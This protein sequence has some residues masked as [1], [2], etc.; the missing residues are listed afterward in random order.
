[1]EIRELTSIPEFEAC[2]ELQREGF[3]WPDLDVMP[4][5]LFIVSR[6]VG[7]L[8]LGAFDAG[9]LVG[10]SSALAGIR[11]NAPY[12]H[13]HMLAVTEA[14]RNRGVGAQLKLAQKAH[15]RD[16]GIS[17]IEWTFDPL[18]SRNAY[19]N[20][21]KLGVVVRRYHPNFYGQTSAAAG[22]GFE[23]DRLVAEWWLDRERPDP[24]GERRRVEIPS[25]IQSIKR[26][27]PENARRIQLRVREQFLENL[28][29]GFFVAGFQ[30]GDPSSAYLFAPEVPRAH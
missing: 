14:C 2:L 7:G 20:I 8:I 4:V 9:R 12:W 29:D 11:A 23:S 28:R 21:E 3:G 10:F 13:S 5:R 30:R 24:T 18:E 15:A 25:D 17:L 26:N 22:T 19:L 1:M 27:N 6:Y 16:R